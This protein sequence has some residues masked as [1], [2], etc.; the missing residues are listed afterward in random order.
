[1]SGRPHTDETGQVA[2]LEGLVFGVLIFVFGTLLVVNAWG[3]VDA[4]L[5]AS[6]AAREAAR[7]YVESDSA[8]DAEAAARRAA[9]ETIEGHGRRWD[10]ATVHM[11]GERFARCARITARIRYEAPLIVVPLVGQHGAGLT[12]TGQHS[13]LVDPY[14]GGLGTEGRCGG[15]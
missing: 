4:K 1:M 8:A 9:R 6:A 11:A 2:G 10:R 3:V 7:S 12:V 14:R 13:E 5:A 15:S